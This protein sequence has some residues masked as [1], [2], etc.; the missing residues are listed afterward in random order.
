M[1][2]P[3]PDE[4]VCGNADDISTLLAAASAEGVETEPQLAKLRQFGCDRAQGFLFKPAVSSHEFAT[5][6][7][8]GRAPNGS[9]Q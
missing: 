5:L 8:A 7:G 9:P 2:T 3:S 6:A 4:V 1:G